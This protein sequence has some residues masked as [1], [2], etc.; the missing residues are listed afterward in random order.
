MASLN[1]LY[2]KKETLEVMLRTLTAK[3]A[4]GVEITISIY[5]EANQFGQNVSAYISQTKEQRDAKKER[6]YVGNGKTFWS[7]DPVNA[8]T[9][10][11]EA[12]K[13]EVVDDGLP[14]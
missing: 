6:F 11:V 7:S 13:A 3:Q 10:K 2:F 8:P 12:V 4:Q 14:F 9:A 1:S 5:D